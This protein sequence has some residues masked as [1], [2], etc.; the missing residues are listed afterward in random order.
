M[1]GRLDGLDYSE[2][3]A[4]IDASPDICP[5]CKKRK[6][7]CLAPVAG[8]H[9]A[10]APTGKASM[11]ALKMIYRDMFLDQVLEKESAR[12]GFKGK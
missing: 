11:C 8:H 12:R 6:C 5:R 7:R 4:E 10:M 9:I 2:L 1:S 3:L